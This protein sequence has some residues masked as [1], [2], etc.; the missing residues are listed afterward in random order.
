MP[1]DSGMAF[2][3][4]PHLAPEHKSIMAELL[5]RYTKMDVSQAEDGM[6][7][8]PN[9]VYIIPP[10][11]DMAML[12]GTLQLLEPVERR[13]LRHPID[14]FFRSLAEDQGE[15]AVC[16]VLSGTGTEGASGLRR[17]RKKADWCSFRTRK[18][19]GT[20]A[21]PAAPSPQASS[22]ISCRPTRC[23]SNYFVT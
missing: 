6:R 19:P 22:T 14:F 7:A 2:V 23:P 12:K 8:N 18:P 3:L 5:K 10:N 13:G 11:K 15:R 17:S 4:I 16:I 9:C 21:C 1:A 20:T